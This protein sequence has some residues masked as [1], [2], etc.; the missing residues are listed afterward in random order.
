MEDPGVSTSA[1]TSP[2]PIPRPTSLDSPPPEGGRSQ[3]VDA[4]PGQRMKRPSTIFRTR[5]TTG[6]SDHTSGEQQETFEDW[7]AR[8]RVGRAGAPD[9]TPQPPA[10]ILAI[11]EGRER[12]EEQS[13]KESEAYFP[14]S[15]AASSSPTSPA[16]SPSHSTPSTPSTVSDGSLLSLSSLTAAT[17]LDFYR[18]KGHFPAPPGPHEEER[19][20]LA[21]KYGL[22]QPVRRQAIDR[23]CGLAKQ[24][25]KTKSVVISLT[26]DDGQVLGAERGW[27]GEEPGLDVPP[28]PLALSPAFCTHAMLASY[29]D[30][31]AVF[32]VPDADADWR[33]KANPYTVGNGGGLSF[34]AAANVALPV[35]EADRQQ[36][37][38]LPA[39]LASGALCLIDSVPR[40]AEAF[41]PE[42]RA[43]L[44][45]LAEMISREFQLGF[46]QRRREQ[47]TAQSDF[48]GSFLHQALVMPA[49]PGDLQQAVADSDSAPSTPPSS[50]AHMTEPSTSTAAAANSP[51]KSMKP[52]PRPKS[53]QGRDRKKEQE[54]RET[55]FAQAARQLRTLTNAG[56]AAILDLRA[57]R[58]SSTATNVSTTVPA[59]SLSNPASPSPT[60]SSFLAG[61]GLSTPSLVSAFHSTS[62]FDRPVP[63][64]G[65][66][67]ACSSP[68][69]RDSLSTQFWRPTAPQASARG[70]VS[71]MGADGDIAWAD[72]FKKR[73][74][75][76][77]RRAAAEAA[78]EKGEHVD[79]ILDQGE[80]TAEETEDGFDPKRREDRKV[81][82]A[83][84]EIIKA[85]YAEM[86]ETAEACTVDATALA[87]YGV[88]PLSKSTESICMP[89]FDVDGAPAVLIVL[90]SGEKWYTFEP[91]DRRFATSVGAIIVGSLLRQRALEA[92]RAKLA[93]VSMVSHE[94]RT[95]LHS[96]NSQIELIR[97]FTSAVELRKLAPFLDAA[98]VSLESLRDVLDDTLDFSKL[99]NAS[100]AEAAD[101][102]RRALVPADLAGIVESVTKSVWIRKH[103]SDLVHTD[104]DK[105][106]DPEAQ[107]LK[108]VLEVD[109]RKGDW[110]VL[111]DVGGIKRIL[112]N[113]LGNAL[114]FTTT[115]EVKL[116]LREVGILPHGKRVVSIVVK[117]TGK[118]MSSEFIR[119]GSHLLPFVQADQFAQGAG[120]GLSIVDSILKRLGGKLEV[121]SE[122]GVGTTMSVTLP[123]DFT[124]SPQSTPKSPSLHASL[125]RVSRRIISDE[126]A[127]LLRPAL[128]SPTLP[129]T[130][131]SEFPSNTSSTD[132][133][134]HEVDFSAT[135]SAAQASLAQASSVSTGST[136]PAALL[137]SPSSTSSIAS[138]VLGI[139][140]EEES[141]VVGAAKL[142]L[143]RLSSAASVRVEPLKGSSKDKQAQ[144]IAPDVKVLCADDNRVA[145]N[146]LIKLFSGK[147]IDYAAA[148]DG[149]EAVEH[150]RAGGGKFTKA[151]LDIQMPRLDGIQAA[152][153]I[154][155][156][157][158][159]QGWS[160]CH[161]T[162]LTGLSNESEIQEAL[163]PGGPV[164]SWLVKGGKS[165]RVILDDVLAQQEGIVKA[166][167]S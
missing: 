152:A 120:L 22:D 162:A 57:L 161:I 34:Y 99:S 68:I 35:P 81:E 24:Y 75:V 32:I 122:L 138:R 116:T 49:Q 16:F 30:P 29:R 44:T 3:S 146:I 69:R 90:T 76:R 78:A 19:L 156:I 134:I 151:Y 125:P 6:D 142:S 39:S 135:V 103:R 37:A 27:G 112:L 18:K 163:R 107:D 132:G 101:L 96:V 80:S 114:K 121:A 17:L 14:T 130:D 139:T 113:L 140:E 110:G 36:N 64:S 88:L 74:K 106:E 56:S 143:S 82:C 95:P 126:I 2:R 123:I 148:S 141:L 117:D 154:R 150:F 157:E 160:P 147:G 102:A 13:S 21:H 111:I 131:S 7:L 26:F 105:P 144:S 5:A 145:L 47:E 118:G 166:R 23:I 109:E 115:G 127:A 8:Y 124:T 20:R 85:Y 51:S 48:V 59:G 15:S 133:S 12:R 167:R 65:R 38:N 25:F 128:T 42:D 28:R 71:L 67:T 54:E 53:K 46:E 41:T 33:F 63:T 70:R 62:T 79:G 91:A 1:P 31:K 98:D 52:S 108:L 137:R 43:V 66:S 104:A 58:L 136:P 40:S 72:I 159:E 84:E 73:K 50:T 55:L 164:D 9:A 119:N 86:P 77:S 165:L 60:A 155:E 10:S 93:F 61:N 149:R 83:V 100:P 87:T 94:L 11:L 45:D 158:A 92:D 129:H 153:E 4:S 97:E 89:I